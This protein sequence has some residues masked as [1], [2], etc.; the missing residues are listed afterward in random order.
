MKIFYN[1]K[2]ISDGEFLNVKDVQVEPEIE[3]RTN[4]NKIY[5]LILHDPNAVGGDKI[6][7]LRANITNND[8]NSGTDILPYVG[9][10]PPP[11]SGMHHYIFELYEKKIENIP[12][13][14]NDRRELTEFKK[15][16]DINESIDKIEFISKNEIGGKRRKTRKRKRRI[17]NRKRRTRHK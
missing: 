12:N 11:N 10:A 8:I 5:T 1:D 6:H 9:P 2:K 14:N 4:P 17:N 3:L 7:W 16:F 15:E 13:L